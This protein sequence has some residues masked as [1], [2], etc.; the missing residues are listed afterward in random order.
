LKSLGIADALYESK[1]YEQ[2]TRVKRTIMI[3]M[4]R[5]QKPIYIQIGT[6]FPMTLSCALMTIKAA[7]SYVTLILQFDG[8]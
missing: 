5:S 8:H 7:Y 3:V 4:M 2:K 6:L 1:W